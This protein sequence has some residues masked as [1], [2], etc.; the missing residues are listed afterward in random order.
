[1]AEDVGTDDLLLLSI[2][3]IDEFITH[4][5]THNILTILGG[6]VCHIMLGV[7]DRH[8]HATIISRILGL[9]HRHLG[10][11]TVLILMVHLLT[12]LP[13]LLAWK[14][15][16]L[17]IHLWSTTHIHLL[18]INSLIIILEVL[19]VVLLLTIVRAVGHSCPALITA[20][21]AVPILMGY[22]TVLTT[23]H[24]AITSSFVLELAH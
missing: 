23:V 20:L 6:F 17:S 14:L 8:W 12:L 13:L 24:T 4:E 18:L 9:G 5:D 3:G 22:T 10:L 2:R 15:R 1:M 7:G 21:E 19:G 16:L 11:T